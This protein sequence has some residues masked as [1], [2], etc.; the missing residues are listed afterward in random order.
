M[1]IHQRSETLQGEPAPPH[2]DYAFADFAAT[3]SKASGRPRLA[4]V[5]ATAGV[6]LAV[7][8]A[9]LLHPGFVPVAVTEA[10]LDVSILPET[11]EHEPVPVPRRPDLKPVPRP[12]E[13]P[14][15][16]PLEEPTNAITVPQKAAPPPPRATKG[17][18]SYYARLFSHLNRYKRYPDSARS[19][20]QEGTVMLRFVMDRAGHVQSFALQQSSGI[21]ALDAEVLALIQR[22]QPLPRMPDDMPQDRLDLIIPVDFK[23]PGHH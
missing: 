2:E 14:V 18:D 13:L 3:R 12:L 20:R 9:F 15:L 1:T 8:L 4:P 16:Q 23:L 10:P 11:P 21:E 5:I 22:A 17:V 6:H 19:K 7:L